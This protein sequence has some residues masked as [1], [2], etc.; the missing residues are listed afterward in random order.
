MS[1]SIRLIAEKA[2]RTTHRPLTLH[3]SLPVGIVSTVLGATGFPSPARSFKST[4]VNMGGDK[5]EIVTAYPVSSI[6]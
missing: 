6:G 1:F 4:A 5:S 2:L 3:H